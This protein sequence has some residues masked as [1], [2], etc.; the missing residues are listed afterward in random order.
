[1]TWHPACCHAPAM[2][3]T[4][5]GAS[6]DW[7]AVAELHARPSDS[8]RLR[9]SPNES[10]P[11]D[12][13]LRHAFA[14]APPLTPGARLPPGACGPCV[15][16]SPPQGGLGAELMRACQLWG[17]RVTTS[18]AGSTMQHVAD[19]R[20]LPIRASPSQNAACPPALY[21]ATLSPQ[22]FGVLEGATNK[23]PIQTMETLAREASGV[24]KRAVWKVRRT[25]DGRRGW[26]IVASGLP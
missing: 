16:G 18:A 22:A 11:A 7:E 8:I 23:L 12:A 17:A 9:R 20:Q 5:A 21:V 19:N 24:S 3:H 10:F 15:P 4:R 13:S 14:G 25:R 6:M 26:D 1:M 2:S